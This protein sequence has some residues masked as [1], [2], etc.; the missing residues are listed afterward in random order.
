MIQNSE[1]K[2]ILDSFLKISSQND[3]NSSILADVAKDCDISESKIKLIFEDGVVG[4]IDFYLQG[5]LIELTELVRSSDDFEGKK[6]REKVN[7]CLFNFYKLQKDHRKSA[8]SIKNFYFDLG[9]LVDK[10][11]GLE[12]AVFAMKSAY[13]VADKIWILLHDQST[14]HNYY[15]KRLTL[16]KVVAKTF[17]AFINDETDDLSKTSDVIDSEIDNV[18]KFE[19]FKREAKEFC[20][21]SQ[22]EI[23]RIITNQDGKLKPISEIMKNLPF[24]RLFN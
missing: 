12:P 10:N 4:I 13:K 24:I 2:Q 17:F 21:K 7:F 1:K 16:S 22:E 20:G 23:A 5:I 3:I 9:N 8:K 11:N 18:M 19:K 15:T 14:D 6:V